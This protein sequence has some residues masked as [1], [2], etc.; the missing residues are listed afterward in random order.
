MDGETFKLD[1]GH[2][3][4]AAITSL[5]EHLEPVG[6]ARRRPAGAQRGGAR[7]CS[8][9]PWVK[10]SLAPGSKVVTEYLERAGAARAA[11]RARLQPRRLRLHDLH[12]QLRPAARRDLAPRSTTATSRSSRVLSRQP[13]LRGPHQ[14]RRED[15]LPRVAAARRRL[16]ARR[17]RW[18]S[19]SSTTRSAT[20]RTAS[21]VY[22]RDIWPSAQEIA[23]TI[24]DAVQS[25]M[26]R[27][28]YGEVFDG[29][30]R[31]NGLEVPDR[32]PLRL[33]RRLDLRAPAAVLRRACRPSPTPVQP[34]SRARACW[35]SSATRSPPTTS[36]RR[37]R[38]SEDSPAGRVPQGARRRA[39]RLQL[40]R[41]AARQPRGDD[42]RHVRQHPPAQPAG[43]R[44]RGRRDAAP[45]RGRARCRSTT[46]R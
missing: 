2:V 19:T 12:R 40:L 14:P 43:A 16:R 20:T 32:R 23:Q 4:I 33:G 31:W 30:E 44:H 21:D 29:D 3:V 5:H 34:T 15:E 36:R 9:Q 17:A 42:A 39:A 41:R 37:A 38:S 7:A 18:T 8:R 22:L 26:F 11:R 1:H 28:S 27:K 10:T 13:Q 35:R 6:D 25:D 46:R 24:E 45:A